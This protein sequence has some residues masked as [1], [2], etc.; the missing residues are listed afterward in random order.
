MSGIVDNLFSWM[1]GVDI[2]TSAT[3]ITFVSIDT[4]HIADGTYHVNTTVCC[5]RTDVVGDVA[6]WRLSATF[7]SFSGTVTQIGSTAVSIADKSAG[8]L[9]APSFAIN[10]ANIELKM[11]GENGKTYNWYAVG[12]YVRS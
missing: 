12:N 4:S 11:T 8:V 3:P 6:A 9:A 2:T 5:N 1:T 7:S 10:G